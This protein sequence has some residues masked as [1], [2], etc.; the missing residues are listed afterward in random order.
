M[1]TDPIQAIRE[2]IHDT[3]HD[4]DAQ[5]TLMDLAALPP[6]T[7]V[8]YLSLSLDW[9]PAGDDPGRTPAFEPR[10]SERRSSRNDEGVSRRPARQHIDRALAELVTTHGPRGAAFES[11]TAD[12]QRIADYLDNE[13]DPAA[14]GVFMVT[15][16]AS[17]VFTPLVLGLPL[18][19]QLVAAPTPALGV[20][21]RLVDDHPTYAILLADQHDATLSLITQATQGHSLALASTDYPRKQKQG[22]WSQQRFQARANE[23]VEAFARGIADEVQRA[24]DEASVTMLIVAGDEVIT[25]ALDAA[26]HPTVTDRI[27][28]TIRLD[29]RASEVEIIAATLPIVARAEREREVEAVRALQDSTGAGSLGVGGAEATLAALQR[30][31]VATLVLNDDFA[32]SGWVDFSLPVYGVGP[33]PI[34][35]P[36][37][38]DPADLTPVAL[39]EELIRLAIQ[40]GATVQIVHTA[41]PVGTAKDDEIPQAGSAQPR[42][43]AA[44]AL[45]HLGGVG[46]LLR[47]AIDQDDSV[48]ER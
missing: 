18:P 44:F 16:S 5:Q 12:A 38:G 29:I 1:A 22:G 15:C 7:A 27:I 47:F 28:D 41:V 34:E 6:S 11:V 36:A 2:Y 43:E 48:T 45:D 17:G 39:E 8:P 13:L 20:L 23:R 10:P 3:P 35:H 42:T 9:R 19:T 31:Q 30:G 40:T 26:F 24:L 14:Q 4:L 25:S 33:V 32:A 21:A 46:A 37:G